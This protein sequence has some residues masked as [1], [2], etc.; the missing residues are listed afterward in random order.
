MEYLITFLEG[1]ISFIS[2]CMLPMLPLYLGYFAGA[3]K[4]KKAL[5]GAVCFVVGF[6]VVFCAL[7]LFAGTVG[8]LLMRYQTAVNVITGLIVIFLGLGFLE[9][10]PLRFFKGIQVKWE[11]RNGFSALVFGMIFAVSLTPCI[12]AFLGSALMLASSSSGSVKGMLLLLVY[13]LGMG[14]P[15]V[16]SA[17]LIEKLQTAFAFIKRHYGVINKVC[18]GFLIL[19]GFLMMTGQLNRLLALLSV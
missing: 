15:F 19:V 8:R 1:I 9:I 4:R 3:A 2:P 12:G 18:G 10:V 6:T 5:Y 7:G 16:I 14:I 11:I 17:V 13:S